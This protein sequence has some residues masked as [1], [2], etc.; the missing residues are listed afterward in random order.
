MQ[1][2]VMLLSLACSRPDQP[3]EEVVSE[4]FDAQRANNVER[5]TELIAA[6]PAIVQMRRSVQGRD[7][8][9]TLLHCAASDAHIEIVELLLQHGADVNAAVSGSTPGITPL[10]LALHHPSTVRALLS[11]R[12]ALSERNG[13]GRTA[14]ENAAR[15][16]AELSWEDAT[17]NLR[18]VDEGQGTSEAR[19]VVQLILDAGA[20]YDLATA[21]LVD[22]LERIEAVVSSPKNPSLDNEDIAERT[23]ALH[24]AAEWGREDACRALLKAGAD[25]DGYAYDWTGYQ[26]LPPGHDGNLPVIAEAVRFPRIVALL[27]ANGAEWKKTIGWQ[28]GSSGMS[29]FSSSSA[30][31]LHYAVQ[32]GEVATVELLLEKGLEVDVRDDDNNTPLLVAASCGNIPMVRF[33]MSHGADPQSQDK[34]GN[35]PVSCAELFHSENR[36]LLQLLKRTDPPT[37]KSSGESLRGE[38]NCK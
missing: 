2:L 21:V 27:L 28:G 33:L 20:D 29:L 36:V 34:F 15:R 3:P 24:V 12:P 31:L 13:E 11:A 5:L 9:R 18:I 35:T 7:G 1:L 22:D 16:V 26:D 37:G 6:Y 30:S 19:N 38:A 8:S 17:S 32:G 10:Q 4:A 23:R 14:L 25:P